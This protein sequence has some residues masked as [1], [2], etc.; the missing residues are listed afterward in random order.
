[1]KVAIAG[2]GVEG[3]SNYTYFLNQGH[4]VVIVDE[5]E[6]KDAPVDASVIWGEGAF[7]RLNGFDMVIRTA[8][9]APW[10]IVTDGK[11]WSAT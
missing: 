5:H 9:L 11:I 8:G 10:K 6:V 3:K 4:E 1:M 2:Y 7:S